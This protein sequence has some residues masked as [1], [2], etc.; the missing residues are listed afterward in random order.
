MGFRAGW[1]LRAVSRE[2]RKGSLWKL[3]VWSLWF[4]D[5][6]SSLGLGV[7]GSG[8]TGSKWS[9]VDVF[10]FANPQ[11]F[12][13]RFYIRKWYPENPTSQVV[14]GFKVLRFKCGLG[15]RV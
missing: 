6:Y 15:V 3:R 10:L 7:W 14:A 4:R 9:S 8:F 2:Q 5:P 13:L 11:N 1:R 12:F